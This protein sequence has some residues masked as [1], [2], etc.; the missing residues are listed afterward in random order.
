MLATDEGGAAFSQPPA[1]ASRS[2]C[3]EGMFPNMDF[4]LGSVV[5]DH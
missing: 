3:R 1:R 2:G 4:H 5:A